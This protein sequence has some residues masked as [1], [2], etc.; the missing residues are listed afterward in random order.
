MMFKTAMQEQKYKTNISKAPSK[1]KQKEV[2]MC[3]L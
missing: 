2:I 1:P 3:C